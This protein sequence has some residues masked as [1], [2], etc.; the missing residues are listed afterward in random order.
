M[1]VCLHVHH[2]NAVDVHHTKAGGFSEM[3]FDRDT[4]VCPP[5]QL[6]VLDTVPVTL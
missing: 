2:T 5:P 3:P 4:H 6:A 1:S